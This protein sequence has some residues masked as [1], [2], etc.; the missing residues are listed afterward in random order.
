MI[1]KV[2][3]STYYFFLPLFEFRTH[4]KLNNI[5]FIFFFNIVCGKSTNTRIV[6]YKKKYIFILIA[7]TLTLPINIVSGVFTNIIHKQPYPEQLRL[8]EE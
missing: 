8:I 2:G 5:M 7:L 3:K 1:E 6:K 4:L